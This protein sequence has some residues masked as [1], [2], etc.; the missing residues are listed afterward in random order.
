MKLTFPTGTNTQ[1]MF[2]F[3]QNQTDENVN[4]QILG[5]IGRN[6]ANITKRTQNV[7]KTN[8][9]ESVHD[10]YEITIYTCAY[11]SCGKM[12]A[13]YAKRGTCMKVRYTVIGS[14]KR[15]IGKQNTAAGL[16]NSVT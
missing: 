9:S 1:K 16:C 12:G 2:D 5:R 11:P 8:K 13:D 15:S 14:A 4:N 7:E 3:I 10:P 6:L